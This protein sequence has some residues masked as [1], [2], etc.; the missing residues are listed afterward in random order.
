MPRAQFIYRSMCFES[1]RGP[2]RESKEQARRDAIAIGLGSYD[3]WGQWFDTV[4]GRIQV[5][6]KSE[7][8]A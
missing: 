4:P 1:P 7:R 5:A 3:D 6:A 2:W 8:A